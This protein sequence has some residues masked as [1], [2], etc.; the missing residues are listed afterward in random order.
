[1]LAETIAIRRDPF[2]L[3]KNEAIDRLDSVVTDIPKY[4]KN[5]EKLMVDFIIDDMLRLINIIYRDKEFKTSRYYRRY[6][7][8]F[9]EIEDLIHTYF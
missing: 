7:D 1:M 8:Y 6:N 9:D 5:L 4:K 3:L 2:H